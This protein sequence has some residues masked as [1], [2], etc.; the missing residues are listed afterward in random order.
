MR[1]L[2][3]PESGT[4]KA[5]SISVPQK[6]MQGSADAESQDVLGGHHQEGRKLFGTGHKPPSL[7][8]STSHGSLP[9]RTRVPR[10]CCT[11]KPSKVSKHRKGEAARPRKITESHPSLIQEHPSPEHTSLRQI[12]FSLMFLSIR[13]LRCIRVDSVTPILFLSLSHYHGTS[14]TR[15][16]AQ[17]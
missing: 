6:W 15:V 3:P 5:L 9:L 14:A 17:P 8:S 4:P 1:A 13:G 7:F 12:S 2:C 11:D 10:S 16:T